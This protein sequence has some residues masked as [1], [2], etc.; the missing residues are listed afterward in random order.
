MS[1]SY[2]NKYYCFCKI[3]IFYRILLEELSNRGLF[4]DVQDKKAETN[5]RRRKRKDLLRMQLIRVIEVALFRGVL[6]FSGGVVDYHSGRVAPLLLEF[7]ES[8]RQN[9]ETDADRDI[10][11]LTSLRLHFTKTICLL[12]NGVSL[13]K[14]RNLF[15]ADF[16][17]SLFLLFFSWCGRIMAND[18][19]Y[20]IF[21]W[22]SSV[23]YK[24]TIFIGKIRTLALM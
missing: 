6:Q 8:I 23:M 15:T 2:K 9:V 17:H 20:F 18:R 4:R 7:L 16:N 19:R 12:I 5:V 11:I 14:R 3:T 10:S 21:F 24:F 22:S 13:E 1:E